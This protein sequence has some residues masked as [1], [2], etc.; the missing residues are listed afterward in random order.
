MR[1]I[2]MQARYNLKMGSLGFSGIFTIGKTISYMAV[3]SALR[4]FSAFQ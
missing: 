3:S 4:N 1:K 2:V